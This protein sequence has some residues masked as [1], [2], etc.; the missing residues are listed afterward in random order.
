MNVSQNKLN[1]YITLYLNDLADYSDDD[2]SCILA[3]SVLNPLKQ[4]IMESKQDTSII[5]KE[6]LI[7]ASPE[8]R[9]ILEDFMLYIQEA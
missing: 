5:L 1:E 3:E 4:L 6:A 7:K 2:Q 9:V 8:K